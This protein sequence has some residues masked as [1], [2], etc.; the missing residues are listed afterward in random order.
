MHTQGGGFSRFLQLVPGE[1]E[2]QTTGEPCV[3]HSLLLTENVAVI[4]TWKKCAS[5]DL[6]VKW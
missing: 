1:G 3:L 2:L 5:V 4:W 6:E